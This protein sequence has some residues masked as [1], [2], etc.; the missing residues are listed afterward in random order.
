MREEEKAWE[1]KKAAAQDAA[2]K[3]RKLMESDLT[4]EKVRLVIQHFFCHDDR[5]SAVLRALH[6]IEMDGKNLYAKMEDGR[7]FQQ[8]F[9]EIAYQEYM[10]K[11]TY[12]ADPTS[13]VLEMGSKLAEEGAISWHMLN[14][15]LFVANWR[16]KGVFGVIDGAPGHGKTD[17]A[18]LL[19]EEMMKQGIHIKTNIKIDGV[20]NIFIFTRISQLLKNVLENHKYDDEKPWIAII[21]E[22]AQLANKKRAMSE[23]VIQFENLARITRKLGGNLLMIVHNFHRDTPS[24]LQD[25]ILDGYGQR[26][27]KKGKKVALIE[28][29]GENVKF[30]DF[31]QNI[32]PTKLK[33]YTTDMAAVQFDIDMRKLWDA[34]AEAKRYEDQRKIILQFL[35]KRRKEGNKKKAKLSP[36]EIAMKVKEIVESEDISASAAVNRV[37]KETGIKASTVNSYYY[38]YL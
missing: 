24:L 22:C 21:D 13:M 38:R 7:T 9:E 23:R 35:K 18:C 31:V 1:M 33:F 30:F 37:A 29:K 27:I 3:F 32:P 6:K 2:Y 20:Q 4:P 11:F 28:L 25:W 10:S 17:F 14:P 19:M 15:S 5:I 36:E 26:Y 34:L 16:E 12:F 8:W